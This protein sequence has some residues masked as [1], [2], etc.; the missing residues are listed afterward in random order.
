MSDVIKP[1]IMIT[2]T[3][4]DRFPP[5][6]QLFRNYES[7]N[8]IL[9]HKAKNEPITEMPKRHE[10]FVWK[11]ARSSGAAPTYFRPCGCFLDG[12]LIANNPT[13]DTLTEIHTIN[14]ALDVVNRESDKLSLDLVVSLG[15]G[16]IPKKQVPVIDV[17]KPDSLFGV[18]KIAVSASALGQLLIE[19]ATQADG[20]VV[21]RAKAWCSMIDVP[22]FRLNPPLSEDIPLDETNNIKLVNMLW[23]TTAYMHSRKSEVQ[24]LIQLL[25]N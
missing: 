24:E 6:L 2:A 21:E 23:E 12:G 9:G 3:V 22:Y 11:T 18:A 8:E 19:Q 14:K 16:A 20:Q 5:A 13:L 17:Y 1:K 10:Q 15:T 4:A 25:L 7:P